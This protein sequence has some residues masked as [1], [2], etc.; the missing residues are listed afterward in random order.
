[1]ENATI[2]IYTRSKLLV[3]SMLCPTCEFCEYSR[4][5]PHH[6]DRTPTEHPS[7]RSHL[8][9][10]C[11]WQ[12]CLFRHGVHG[13]STT[14]G[15]VLYRCTSKHRHDHRTASAHPSIRSHLTVACPRQLCLFWSWD[16]GLAQ[17]RYSGSCA[18]NQPRGVAFTTTQD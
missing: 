16:G 13:G 9:V 12:L 2:S 6:L 14:T 10:A 5:G 8:T 1:M 18:P 11:L 7:I 15:R 3:F 4:G 17:R